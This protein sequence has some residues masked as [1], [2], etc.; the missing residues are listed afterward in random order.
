MKFQA[1]AVGKHTKD[2]NIKFNLDNNIVN[3]EE[4]VKHLGVTIAFKFNLDLHIPDKKR[5]APHR[6]AQTSGRSHVIGQFRLYICKGM[7][8]A[9]VLHIFCNQVS[10]M[11]KR[12]LAMNQVGHIVKSQ[13]ITI[14]IMLSCRISS[15]NG[16][17][18]S[19][20]NCI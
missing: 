15:S 9:V 5:N 12:K 10:K 8:G 11:C 1:I 18:L 17:R 16:N 6:T 2:K 4:H 19:R 13:K 3:C 14:F 7:S 20:P